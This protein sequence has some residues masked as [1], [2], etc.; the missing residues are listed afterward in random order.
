M[1]AVVK[2]SVV[3]AVLVFALSIAMALTGLHANP[4]LGGLLSI[5]A[6]ILIDIGCVFM[7]LKQT[8]PASSYVK[9]LIN[10]LLIGVIGGALVFISSWLLLEAIFPDYL[11]EMRAGYEEW[12]KAAGLPE[13][14][15]RQQLAAME[16]ATPASQSLAGLAGTFFTSLVAGAILGIF[17]RKK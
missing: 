3:L 17:L 2:W 14:Q 1:N 5:V 13:D 4:L 7:A 15:V 6:A 10:G 9:Q 8:A 11:D 12:T 16:A